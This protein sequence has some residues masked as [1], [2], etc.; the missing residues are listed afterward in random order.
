[1]VD[2]LVVQP[3]VVTMGH[4]SRRSDHGEVS[5][6]AIPLRTAWTAAWMRL[7]RCSL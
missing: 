5:A 6:Q 1:V 3:A 4:R 7:S 2:W